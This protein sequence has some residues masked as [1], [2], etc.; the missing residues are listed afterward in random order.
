MII[1]REK[2]TLKIPR[3]YIQWQTLSDKVV[4]VQQQPFSKGR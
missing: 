4:M 1:A 3:I 2:K